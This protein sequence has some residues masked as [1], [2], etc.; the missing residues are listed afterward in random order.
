LAQTHYNNRSSL[1]SGLD[2]INSNKKTEMK[3]Q[4]VA[5]L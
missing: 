4:M 1:G 2:L 3:L 5:E